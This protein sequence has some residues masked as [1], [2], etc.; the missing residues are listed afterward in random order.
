VFFFVV[1]SPAPR[2]GLEGPGAPR[3]DRIH[4]RAKDA[5]YFAAPFFFFLLFFF[6]LFFFFF[7]GALFRPAP[8]SEKTTRFLP[9][10]P[11]AITPETPE[12]P[13]RSPLAGS[14]G[15]RLCGGRHVPEREPVPLAHQRTRRPKPQAPRALPR[16]DIMK[17]SN[18]EARAE[19]LQVPSFMS[20]ASFPSD[21]GG[22]TPNFPIL[23]TVPYRRQGRPASRPLPRPYKMDSPLIPP[24]PCYHFRIRLVRDV[25]C[26]AA[27]RRRCGRPRS[28]YNCCAKALARGAQVRARR[29]EGRAPM[30]CLG[31][32][33]WGLNGR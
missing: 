14:P 30:G 20:R 3:H 33:G 25:A 22:A 31:W 1:K 8:E 17:K 16:A 15:G 2:A 6:P 32:G 26:P 11:F 12:R 10:G 13:V 5:E 4:A 19:L 9:L 29:P 23:P 18:H 24:P 21:G 7:F 27:G 28:T